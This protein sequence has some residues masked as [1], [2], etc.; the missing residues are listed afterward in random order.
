M[1]NNAA[2]VV[3]MYYGHTTKFTLDKG[4]RQGDTIS[5]ERHEEQQLGK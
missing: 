1:Y 2:A 4:V 3:R 5:A